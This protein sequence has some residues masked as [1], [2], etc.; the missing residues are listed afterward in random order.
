MSR[1]R[2]ASAAGLSARS[3]NVVAGLTTPST[4]SAAPIMMESRAPV[5]PPELGGGPGKRRSAEHTEDDHG[6]DP[7]HPSDKKGKCG[8]VRLGDSKIKIVTVM[9]TELTRP[10]RRSGAARRVPATSC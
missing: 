9:G 7:D 10:R 3:E 6:N 2:R 1:L 8:P 4:I 5:T